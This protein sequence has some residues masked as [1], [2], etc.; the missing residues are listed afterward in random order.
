[1]RHLQ[2]EIHEPKKDINILKKSINDYPC[3]C[4]FRSHI[5]PPV[6]PFSS[7]S[8]SNTPTRWSR[9]ASLPVVVDDDGSDVLD[10]EDDVRQNTEPTSLLLSP[11]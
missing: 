10:E 5:F 9:K 7:T 2:R 6:L 1:M 3:A 8:Y 11:E 4:Y